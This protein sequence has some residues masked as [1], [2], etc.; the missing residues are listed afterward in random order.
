VKISDIKKYLPVW[1]KWLPSWLLL[2]DQRQEGVAYTWMVEARGCLSFIKKTVLP[3]KKLKPVTICTGIKN[4]TENYLNY[5]L[6]SL[7]KMKNQE[8]ICLS[9]FDCN[10]EDS[11]NIEDEIRKVWK[12]TLIFES[13]DVPFT[14]SYSFN[15]AIENAPSEIIFASDADL[16]LPANLVKLCNIYVT[17]WT[18]W[19]PVFFSLKQYAEVKHS[20]ENGYWYPTSLGMFAA[21]KWQFE[22]VGKFDEKYKKWGMEDNDLWL[23]FYRHGFCPFRTRPKGLF[24]HWHAYTQ[25]K[26]EFLNRRK[27]NIPF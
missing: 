12:G 25:E 3:G 18:V 13:A 8:L 16:T 11:K 9:V 22:K 1:I 23:R 10:S 6:P 27:T 2:A 26:I 17:K 15:K 14:R 4:R 21:Y 24:H 19:F 5:V 20:K 7:L